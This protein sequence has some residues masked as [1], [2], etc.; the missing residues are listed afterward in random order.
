MISVDYVALEK[1]CFF[2]LILGFCFFSS[3]RFNWRMDCRKKTTNFPLYCCS[4]ANVKKVFVCIW[5]DHFQIDSLFS[6]LFT[7]QCLFTWFDPNNNVY[8]YVFIRWNLRIKHQHTKISPQQ[9]KKIYIKSPFY[10]FCKEKNP[11]NTNSENG[12]LIKC[13]QCTLLVE[14]KL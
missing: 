10:Q 12:E 7:V 6:I 14:K 1:S 9:T 3:S 8:R 5:I 4:Y 11:A 13:T 2:I